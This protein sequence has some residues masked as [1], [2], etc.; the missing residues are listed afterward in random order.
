MIC[1]RVLNV[2]SV[3]GEQL[4]T[5]YVGSGTITAVKRLNAYFGQQNFDIRA[6]D[7]VKLM[8]VRGGVDSNNL[9]YCL[10]QNFD[11]R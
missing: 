11:E 9:Q 7:K 4:C 3:S 10:R 5:L 2:N 8:V 6:V 1:V